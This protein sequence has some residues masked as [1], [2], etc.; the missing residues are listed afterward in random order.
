MTESILTFQFLDFYSIRSCCLSMAI[1]DTEVRRNSHHWVS[2]DLLSHKLK[3]CSIFSCPMANT[4]MI[5]SLSI[6]FIEESS[7]HGDHAVDLSHGFARWSS[8]ERGS[9][10]FERGTI[11]WILQY[12][13][14]KA[15]TYR[16]TLFPYDK[17]S[18]F[19]MSILRCIV[20]LH[21][22]CAWIRKEK[23]RTRRHSNDNVE[24]KE[25]KSIE[26]TTYSA[27][28][29]IDMGSACFFPW[30]RI[31]SFS[32]KWNMVSGRRDNERESFRTKDEKGDCE[33]EWKGWKHSIGLNTE[34]GASLAVLTWMVRFFNVN[35][36]DRMQDKVSLIISI[37][38]LVRRTDRIDS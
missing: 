1:S 19:M 21:F 23:R 18:W 12:D 5:T 6:S 32:T 36:W 17:R 8:P 11:G 22:S 2:S 7:I 9:P 35:R 37:Y 31:W 29:S 30:M 38:L 33:R 25:N 27:K 14:E 24:L 13:G 3:K 15:T 34:A 4:R 10:H 20:W 16:R 28:S 26:N